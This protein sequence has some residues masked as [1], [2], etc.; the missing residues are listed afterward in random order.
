MLRPQAI[1]EIPEQTA[2][3]AHAA[4]PKGNVAMR[5]RDELGTL[6]RDEDFQHL[7]PVTGQPALPP[8]RLALVTVLQFVEN[9]T[10][11]QAAD[12]VRARIDWKHALGLDLDHAGF[13]RSVLSEFRAR[14][15]SGNAE[16]LLLDR[17]L[18]QL[19]AQGL[20][21]ARGKQRTDSTHIL[22]AIRTLNRL[23]FVGET[24]RAALN[25]LAVAAPDW[26]RTLAPPAWFERYGHRVEEYR[27]PK[28]QEARAAYAAVIGTDGFILLDALD[29]DEQHHELRELSAVRLLRQAWTQHFERQEGGVRLGAG[30]E[31][32]P[33]GE[34]F[35]SPYDQDAQFGNKR[36]LT[37]TGYKVH[38]T[39]SCDD[40]LPHLITHVET[41]RAVIPDISSGATIHTALAQKALLPQEH[42]V[43]GGYVDA[44]FLASSEQDHAVTVIGPAK[45][46]VSW[47]AHTEGAFDVDRFQVDWAQHRAT[48]PQGKQSLPWTPG[49]NAF[50]TAVLHVKFRTRDC[51][52]CVARS[53]CTKAVQS[54]RHL[55]LQPQ[56]QHEALRAARSRQQTESWQPLYNRR[57][58]IEGTLSQAVRTLGLRHARYRGLAKT[59]LEHVLIA[60]AINVRRVVAWLEGCP[61]ETTRTSRFQALRP[62]A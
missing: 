14:L 10:D 56:A 6:Y 34:R 29:A 18:E 35:E 44:D 13:D 40:D 23:E 21:K 33:A 55:T 51:Q 45:G 20:L 62:V 3:I 8:W 46:S 17:L 57:A 5:L 41:T 27:L 4:F 48:C 60:A 52:A 26:M 31:L 36:S 59:D 12:Q 39:E 28:G 2:R 22:A 11:R 9:L 47:Q 24:L 15:V 32:P 58:G 38:L 37:W 54:P 42:L 61:R 30:P 49:V 25:D 16:Q 19:K 53:L 50:G 43:D 7:F 1:G